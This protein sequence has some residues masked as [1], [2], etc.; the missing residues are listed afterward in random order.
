MSRE[1]GEWDRLP[2]VVL[3]H[4]SSLM[5]KLL[6]CGVLRYSCGVFLER[7]EWGWGGVGCSPGPETSSWSD[8]VIVSHAEKIAR[9]HQVSPLRVPQL[10]PLTG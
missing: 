6:S 2:S 9:V 4:L 8:T 3:L 1:V 5:A 7:S 10:I